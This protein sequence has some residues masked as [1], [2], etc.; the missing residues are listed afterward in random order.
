MLR[1]CWSVAGERES[2]RHSEDCNGEDIVGWTVTLAWSVSQRGREVVEPPLR[3][4]VERNG[5]WPADASH[6]H[7]H[8]RQ[9]GTPLSDVTVLLVGTTTRGLT[10][11]NGRYSL[12]APS[13]GVLSFTKVGRRPVQTTIAGRTTIDITMASIAYLDEVVVT[14]YGEQRR[15]DITGAVSSLNVDAANRET[16]ASVLQ[17]LDEVPGITVAAGGSPGARTTVRIRGISSFQNNDPLYIIDGTPVQDS[18]INFLNPDDIASIQVLKDAS[19]ASIYGARASNGV[20]VIDTKK[21]TAGAPRTTFRMRTG[22]ASPVKGYNDLLIQNPL[23]YFQV[24][25]ASYVN[26]GLPVPTN[27]YGDPN[28]PTIPKYIFA[29][30]GTATQVDAYGR[31]VAVDPSKYSYPNSLIMASSAGTDWWKEMFAAAPLADYNLDV[32][33]GSAETRYGVSFNFFDQNGTAKYNQYQRGS[34]RVNTG[35]TRGKLNFGENIALSLDRSYGG[36]PDDPGGYAEDGILGKNILMQPVI[37]VYDINGNFAGGKATGLGNQSNPL[38][39]AFNAK[40]NVNRNNRV[41][42]N[43]YGGFEVLPQLG[44]KS[45][46]GFN[47]RQAGFSGYNPPFPENAEATFTN[48]INENSTSA[49]DWTW[50][51]TARYNRTLS[52]FGSIDFLA[53]EEA[54]A[55]NFRFISASMSSL[56]NTD[57]NSRFIQ[58]ALGDPATKNVSSTGG[59]T[60]LLSLFTKV[61]YNYADKYIASATVR[62]DGSSNLGPGHQW[63]TFPAFGLGWRLTNEPFF[64]H[65]N[66]FSDVMLRYGFGVTGNQNIPSGRVV[67]QFG[68]NRGDTF[69]DIN[70]S[71]S[72]IVA[73]FRQSSLGN[74][75]LK[76]EEN[77]STNVGTDMSLFQNRLNVV[78]DIYSRATNNLLFNPAT[79]G[80]AGIAAPPIVNIGK[81]KNTGY[82]F[83]IGHSGATW[84]ANF[85]GSHYKNTIVSINGVQNFFYGPITTRYGNQVINQVGSPIGS[86]YGYIADGYF[87]DAADVAAYATQD[88]AAPGRI[89]FRD[90]NGDKKIDPNDRTIIGS[91]HPNFTAGLD[92]GYRRGN[93]DVGAT[94]FGTYGNKIWNAQKEFTVFRN[95]ETNVVKRSVG[96]FVDAHEPER[97]VSA[98]RCERPVQPRAQQLLRRGRVVHQ[99]AQS[100]TGVYGSAVDVTVAVGDESLR[101]GGEPVHEDLVQRS[102]SGIAGGEHWWVR[103][104][105]PGSVSRRR[106]RFVSHQQDVHRRPHNLVLT[107]RLF[108]GRRDHENGIE[109]S[110]RRDGVTESRGSNVVWLLEILDRRGQARRDIEFVNRSPIRRAS[111]APSLPRTGRWTAPATPMATGDAPRAIGC[112]RVSPAMIRTKDRT[113]PTSRRSTTSRPTIGQMLLVRPERYEREKSQLVLDCNRDEARRLRLGITASRATRKIRVRP[114]LSL[115]VDLIAFSLF[116]YPRSVCTEAE[117]WATVLRWCYW[118]VT[119]VTGFREARQPECYPANPPKAD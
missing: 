110:A 105:H 65:S 39:E 107:N 103:R 118:G 113:A 16:G 85:Q 117:E 71:N 14:A 13:D 43:V 25:K 27:I 63:G 97:Q 95:F 80:T 52:R 92:L 47:L 32:N 66:I 116:P 60:A 94:I 78:I 51:N 10:G 41:F 69:Y 114:E 61:G 76:W 21:G 81:M 64:S 102:R 42:G 30:A 33:G 79:P 73:G 89:K 36:L 45:S 68:G 2:F 15:G 90:V 26:A 111:K 55:S 54:N 12:S 88:G 77:R 11:P 99:A 108:Q 6:R 34:V 70:G 109:T 56:I 84:S 17:R 104:R 1:F 74:P 31:P 23:D 58:D 112:G 83:S 67:S 100:A 8:V 62:R 82:D 40:D 72:S 37:P 18:Y 46:L 44:V 98:A 96:Q 115:F 38:K 5:V 24:V 48:S 87:K 57:V 22:Y 75:D 29:A 50:T 106:P 28:A 91:P 4:G 9:A 101:A 59:Q 7:R 3:T 49:T 19:E 53:G 93:W 119:E 20:I 86:F 35:F